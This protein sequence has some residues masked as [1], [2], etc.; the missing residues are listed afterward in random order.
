MKYKEESYL[1]FD[2]KSFYFKSIEIIILS[3]IVIIP[4]VFYLHCMDEYNP[5][6]EATAGVLIVIG[7]MLWGLNII[8]QKNFHFVNLSL[9]LPIFCFIIICLLSL[10]W[11]NNLTM[12]IKELPL[13]L[14]GP[15]LYFII[16]NNLNY[17]KHVD[18]ILT[19]IFIIGGLFG[20]YGILQYFGIDFSFW[21]GNFG[22]QKV[23]GLFGNVNFF[24]EYLIIPLPISITF[25]L[26]SRKKIFNIYL[27]FAIFTMGESLI[28]TF[29]RGSYLGFAVSLI[30][31]FLLFLKIQGKKFIYKN[32]K[33]VVLIVEFIL[34]IIT[35]LF[36]MAHPINE[37]GINLSEF[38]ERISISKVSED[39]SFRRRI[40]IWKFTGLMIKDRPLLG[41][42]IG[43]YKYNTLKYQAE[44]FAQGE[45]RSLYPHG[46]ADKAHNEY[47]QLWAELGIIGLGIFTWFIISY[48]RFGLKIL[49]KIKDEYRQGIIIG[50]MG[51]IVAILV[52][53]LFGFPFHLPASIILFWI[54]LGLSVV[55]NKDNNQIKERFKKKRK[56]DRGFS[57]ELILKIMIIS[58]SIF[59]II[60]LIRPFMARVD[61]YYGT[62]ELEN[63]NWDGAINI[64]SDAVRWDPWFGQGYYDIGYSLMRKGLFYEAV[65]YFEKAQKYIDLSGL[66]NNLAAVYINTGQLDKGMVELKQAILYQK[67]EKL[68]VPL[69]STLGSVYNKQEK[70]ELAEKSFKNALKIDPDFVNAHYGLAQVY[71]QQNRVEEMQE[72]LEI[73]ITLDPDSKEAKYSMDILQKIAQEKLKSQ[74]DKTDN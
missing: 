1:N 21:E 32:N 2:E 49:R 25:F 16:I 8:N 40:A 29:T 9:N 74:T 31:M 43:T 69:Y 44:F 36:I 68:M 62:K 73:V 48:F 60:T 19:V 53:S 3:L 28:F 35:A 55:I 67:D 51:V 37:S 65:K 41:S 57:F 38:K 24:A 20:I 56:L 59:L 34:I 23:S 11:S 71:Y 22:R 50:L 54:V 70:T 27:L 17:P 63:E 12:S 13:F 7:L 66:P 52:D 5:I 46:F 61:W 4:I 15:C 39:S 64:C 14:M 45:N 6:K 33:I 18:K 58:F 26:A 42:G 30:F 47:L 10:I 72:E